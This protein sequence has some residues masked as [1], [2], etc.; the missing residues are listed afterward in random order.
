MRNEIIVY[1]SFCGKS[2]HNVRRLIAGPNV[3]ICNECIAISVDILL[4][5]LKIKQDEMITKLDKWIKET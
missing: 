3:F 2:Q 1:C 4:S 5:E